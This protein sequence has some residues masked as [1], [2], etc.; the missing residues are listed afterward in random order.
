MS[1]QDL[2]RQ[3]A[4]RFKLRSERHVNASR[5]VKI[6]LIAGGSTVAIVAQFMSVP[7]GEPF[8]GWQIAGIAAA[9][10]AGFGA[11]FVVLTEEDASADLENARAAI[12]EARNHERDYDDIL[13]D[14]SKF[15]RELQ[16]AIELYSSVNAMRGVVERV[17]GSRQRDELAIVPLLMMAA[18][19]P[20]PIALG[21]EQSH[22]W[23]VCIYRA[24]A[25]S[26][27]NKTMLR[28]VAHLRS[29]DCDI[30]QARSWP[31]GVGVA[32]IAY[33]K[34]S[35]LIVP[36]MADPALGTVFNLRADLTRPYDAER[37]R[38]FAIVPIGVDR[39]EKPWGVIIGTTDQPSHFNS[40]EETGLRTT[41]GIRAVAGM[42]ALAVAASRVA[43]IEVGDASA[44]IPRESGRPITP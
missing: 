38:S 11:I 10:V 18:K 36:D 22:R 32:G 2:A 30:S 25:D 26:D 3:T 31:E 21:F 34:N 23:T 41:E 29:I 44:E 16:R 7:S 24:E 9:V 15:E 33:A 14:F 42:V 5:F 40:G 28:C 43:P 4:A 20:L 17:L 37:Y 12:E 13:T 1:L 19:R 35:E 39:D 27:T 8:G 6:G